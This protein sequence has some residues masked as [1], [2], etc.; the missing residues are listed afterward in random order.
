M[1]KAEYLLQK[2]INHHRKKHYRRAEF[3]RFILRTLFSFE[4]SGTVSIGTN[5]EFVHNGLGCVIHPK[6][7]IGSNVSIYQNTT[8]GGNTKIIDG[9][10]TNIGAPII[11]DNVTICAGACVLGPIIIGENV[12][13]GANAVVTR[14]VPPNSLAYGNPMKITLLQYTLK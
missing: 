3:F 9:E 8:L 6:T 5:V 1:R 2:T 14:D 10:I 12:V 13:I 4:V 7:V 11:K